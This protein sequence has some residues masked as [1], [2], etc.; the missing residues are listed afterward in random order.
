MMIDDEALRLLRELHGDM[1]EV[2]DEQRR[3]REIVENSRPPAQRLPAAKRK[4]LSALLPVIARL[5]GSEVFKATDVVDAYATAEGEGLRVVLDPFGDWGTKRLGKLF[6]RG[7]G[8][9]ID[10]YIVQCVGD[11]HTAKLWRVRLAPPP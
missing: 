5:F 2:R 8:E 10:G 9:A 6:G 11:D 3:L 4:V 1:R 7:E